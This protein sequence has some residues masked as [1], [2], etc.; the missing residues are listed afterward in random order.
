LLDAQVAR[1]LGTTKDTIRKVRDRSHW[2]ASNIKPRNPVLLGLCKQADLDAALK[3]AS[4]RVAR[5]Q[6]AAAKAGIAPEAQSQPQ[7]DID[8]ETPPVQPATDDFVDPATQEQ[9][10][11]TDDDVSRGMG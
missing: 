6:K 8:L 4:R 9:P 7:P 10:D 1:L 11:I 2:N 3:R 5:E